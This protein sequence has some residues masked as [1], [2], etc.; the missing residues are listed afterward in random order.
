MDFFDCIPLAKATSLIDSSLPELT[1]EPEEV[2]LMQALGRITAVDIAAGVDL[3]P[4]S[5]STV[6]GYAVLSRDT[7]G[8]GEG[9]P[10]MLTVT[11]E[12][13]M[14]QSTEASIVSGQAVI[15]PT[16]GMLPAGADAVVM[17]EHTERSDHETLLVLKPA[18]PGENVV[19]K[20]EDIK[21]GAMFIAAGTKLTP[22]E[23]G[24]LA[25]C[26]IDKVKVR[27]RLKVGIISTGD[28]VVDV[29][30]VPVGGQVRDVNSY[31]LAAMLTEA[32]C[33]VTSYGIIKDNY[34]ELLAAVSK[35][36]NENQL[37]LA[38]GG[39]SVGA[40]DHTVQIIEE[41]GRQKVVFHGLAVKPGKPTIFGMV[42]RVPVFGLPGHP[43]AAMT[44][45]QM[46]VIPVVKRLQG[47]KALKAGCKIS[48]RLTRNCASAPGRDDFL[49]VKLIWLEGEYRAEPVL[50][51]SGLISV[52][53]QA[54]GVVQVP[55]G[56]SG[57]Y[58]GDVVTVEVMR[59]A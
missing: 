28:E 41:L 20:G 12:V 40:R 3:P 39:S 5:R 50:G 18:A 43:V 47:L 46:L 6:D 55:E 24:A 2:G 45:C 25:A 56:S 9:V 13:F 54:D 36:V 33:H 26:G 7:F 57:L 32:G 44:I 16:G 53:T 27:Q 52:M 4:F 8:A 11:D 35:G 14:G 37:V 48:A 51:K 1:A 22:A 42:G 21:A 19:T 49:R 29:S 31:T 38:S 34:D 15:M 58:A 23:I 17:L 59:E 10:V 30:T